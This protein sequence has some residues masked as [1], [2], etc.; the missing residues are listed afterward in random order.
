MCDY[1]LVT[2]AKNEGDNLPFV[3][4]SVTEQT[5]QPKV[6]LIVD[7]GSTDNTSQIIQDAE[8]KYDWVKSIKLPP[9]P[10]DIT[11][12]Y[13]FVCK[14]GFDWIISYCAEN[15]IEYQYIGLLDSDTELSQ[16]FFE[17][18]LIAMQNDTSLG[19]V[20]GGV[21]HIVNGELKWN[22]SNENLP[23]GT[24]RVWRRECFFQTGGYIVEPAPDSISNVKAVLRGWKIKK[25]KNVIAVERRMTSSAE[26][27]W[28][29][30]RVQGEITYYFNKH[31]LLVLL[32]FANLLIKKPHYTCFAYSLGYLSCLVKRLPKISDPEIRDY[33]RNRR[34]K[35]YIKLS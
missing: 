11:F 32:N 17:S 15:E 24:G 23:A 18:L 6:W 28:K 9:H 14:T 25:F 7:D 20:S 31:P 29:G 30:H 16:N 26:G 8:A 22:Q 35:E 19:I 34:L 33:Y 3:L 2:P 10:R 13:S 12:H 5:I 4:K 27:L 21:H 1:I